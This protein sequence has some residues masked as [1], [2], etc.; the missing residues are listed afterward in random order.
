M[1]WFILY[2]AGVLRWYVSQL[3]GGRNFHY[4]FFGSALVG[5]FML[6]MLNKRA[7]SPVAIA[8]FICGFVSVLLVSTLTDVHL[9]GIAP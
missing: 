2:A 1:N 5:V 4:Q 7:K 6:G 8:A 9:C 3:A